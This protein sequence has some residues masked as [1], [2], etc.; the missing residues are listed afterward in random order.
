MIASASRMSAVAPCRIFA[1]R[2]RVSEASESAIR[3]CGGAQA[4]PSWV[5]T[6]RSVLNRIRMSMDNDQFST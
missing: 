1:R 3:P 6:T 5:I 2:C 4:E